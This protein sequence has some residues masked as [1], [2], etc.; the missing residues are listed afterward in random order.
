MRVDPLWDVGMKIREM[1]IDNFRSLQQNT[2][3]MSQLP[4][5]DDAMANA[6][7]A[8]QLGDLPEWT[9][10]SLRRIGCNQN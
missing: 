7:Q 10:S 1:K 6:E 4:K 9:N 3:I 8:K 2:L 5:K